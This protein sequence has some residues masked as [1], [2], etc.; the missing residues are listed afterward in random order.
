MSTIQ[1][2]GIELSKNA[3]SINRDGAYGK[4]V[5]RKTAKRNRLLETFDILPPC[6]IGMEACSGAHHWAR[7]LSKL[8]H[9]PRIMVSKF[10]IPYRQNEKTMPKMRKPYVKQSANLKH[11]LSRL[12][13][14]NNKLSLHYTVFDMLLL[15]PP[16]LISYVVYSPSSALLFLK[17]DTHSKIPFPALLNILKMGYL[18][19][20]VS[21]F[22]T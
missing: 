20:L 3:F 2:T 9:T 13:V 19:W 7:E 14:L 17:V 11:D 4:C 15:A 12:K 5:L 22:I 1:T 18:C 21:C 6:F 8:G 10:V 16:P